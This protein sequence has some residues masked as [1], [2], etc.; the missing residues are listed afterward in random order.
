[1]PPS[2]SLPATTLAVTS[3]SKL[4]C[5][6]RR[7]AR[8]AERGQT[9]PVQRGFSTR[10]FANGSGLLRIFG[11][12]H[13]QIED[14]IAPGAGVRTTQSDVWGTF[15]VEDSASPGRGARSAR[16]P[17]AQFQCLRSGHIWA[18]GVRRPRQR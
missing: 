2:G 17:V 8:A 5:T 15:S 13:D 12:Y 18:R 3:G 1:M 6:A 7:V 9:A 10:P 14:P 11:A 16:V 4:M